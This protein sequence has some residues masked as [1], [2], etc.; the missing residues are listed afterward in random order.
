MF[1]D[2][3]MATELKNTEGTY[4]FLAQSARSG[5]RSTRSR[6]TCGRLASQRMPC[7]TGRCHLGLP[8]STLKA[9]PLPSWGLFATTPLC[10]LPRASTRSATKCSRASWT[11]THRRASRF[12]SCCSIRG[13]R[14][15]Y[16]TSARPSSRCRRKK[17]ALRSRP[18]TTLFSWYACPSDANRDVWLLVD[19][20]QDQV[21]RQ[22]HE[23]ATHVAR[24]EL[25][26]Q[27]DR[28]AVAVA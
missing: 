16:T 7:C 8:K 20:A 27:L 11:R 2:D 6:S 15:R 22:A 23:G 14:R 18:S 13:S 28:I 21:W 9:A 3:D 10:C 12:R 25:A 1:T 26:E 4:H 19:E 17:S 5:L 24:R